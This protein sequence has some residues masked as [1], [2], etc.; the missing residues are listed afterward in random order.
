MAA[1]AMAG[2]PTRAADPLT[3]IPGFPR[4]KINPPTSP[5]KW[6]S[7]LSAQIPRVPQEPIRVASESPEVIL[8]TVT[9]A[10]RL[11]DEEEACPSLSLEDLVLR[12]PPSPATTSS[13]ATTPVPTPPSGP[14]SQ[15]T[16]ATPPPQQDPDRTS[17]EL[18]PR[19]RSLRSQSQATP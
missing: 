4:K 14:R 9:E 8:R 17:E 5:A 2:A 13:P 12:T 3:A 15:R 1:G 6:G 16:S 7:F 18:T 10:I 11:E 19:R